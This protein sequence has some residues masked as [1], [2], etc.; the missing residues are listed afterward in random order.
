M[1]TFLV[2]KMCRR[3]PPVPV[4]RL[5]VRHPQEAKGVAPTPRRKRANDQEPRA[6]RSARGSLLV[7]EGRAPNLCT[8][9]VAEWHFPRGYSSD[10]RTEGGC[11]LRMADTPWTQR[12]AASNNSEF[13]F[14]KHG[15]RICT[16]QQVRTGD[17]VSDRA[18]S[19]AGRRD[20]ERSSLLSPSLTSGHG[21]QHTGLPPRLCSCGR[22]TTNA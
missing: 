15:T 1:T 12:V 11:V 16:R 17:S 18:H 10:G 21:T 7:F 20:H 4:P 2:K 9:P 14:S 19:I 13:M 3:T 6:A 5:R 8:S 22:T